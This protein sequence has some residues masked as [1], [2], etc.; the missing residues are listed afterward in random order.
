MNT[1]IHKRNEPNVKR[2]KPFVPSL[3]KAALA[4]IGS[5]FI[6]SLA[7]SYS[8]MATSLEEAVEDQ[9]AYSS[10]FRYKAGIDKNWDVIGFKDDSNLVVI[11]PKGTFVQSGIETEPRYRVMVLYPRPSSAYDVAISKIL[12]VFGERDIQAKFTVINFQR[13][14]DSGQKAL[15]LAQRENVDL[16]YA[17]GSQS[18]L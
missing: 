3:R 10:W 5:L 1:S 12:G 7:S 15:E 11:R 18:T 9:P 13:K 14:D 17:M 4:F 16:I 2:R 8:A 6:A